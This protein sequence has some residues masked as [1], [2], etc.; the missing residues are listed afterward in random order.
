[1]KLIISILI[2]FNYYLILHSQDSTYI[3]LKK[4]IYSMY[5][6]DQKYRTLFRQY[7]NNE[8]DTNKYSIKIISDSMKIADVENST[9]IQSILNEFGFPGF[10][11]VG[12]DYSDAFWNILQHQ[13]ENL[14]LQ[15]LGLEKM[16]VEVDKIML[17]KCIMLI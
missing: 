6:L 1:M 16:K 11:K 2:L 9:E 14:P 7:Q 5:V 12:K 13:D 10:S 8:I 3:H 15:I 17:Q 4:K